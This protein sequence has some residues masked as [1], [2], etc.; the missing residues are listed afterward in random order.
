MKENLKFNFIE[1]KLR[2]VIINKCKQASIV[3]GTEDRIV[4]GDG[5]QNT[6]S[7]HPRLDPF[8]ILETE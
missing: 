7:N 1:S 3:G 6:S 5:T 2:D 8:G 4:E